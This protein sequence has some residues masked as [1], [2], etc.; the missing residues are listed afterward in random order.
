MTNGEI[1]AICEA[2]GDRVDGALDGL[3]LDLAFH[4]LATTVGRMIATGG[5]DF[6]TTM[7]L[8]AALARR[9]YEGA[10]PVVAAMKATEH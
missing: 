3:R 1:D 9:Q 10:L 6:D 5:G 7:D 4:V 2:A 8:L